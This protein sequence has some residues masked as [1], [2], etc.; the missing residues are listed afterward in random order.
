M[1]EGTPQTIYLKDYQP[2]AFLIDSVDLDIDLRDEQAT[3]RAVLA[4]RRNRACAGGPAPLVLD[5]DDLQF[6]S[7]VLDGTPLPARA[8]EATA[9]RFLLPDAPDVFTLETTVRISPRTNTTLSGL[10]CSKDGYFTQ[11]EA[12]GFR[13]ITYFI[14]RPDV[15]ARY[16]TTIHADRRRYP[17]LLSNG[18]LADSGEEDTGR[19]WARWVDP[20]PKPSYLFAMVAANLEVL[21]DTYRTVSGRTVQLAIYVEPGKLD[22]CGW[23]MQALKKAMKWDEEVFGL[24]VDLDQY[25]IVAVGDFNMGA[26]ENKGLNIFNTKY[27]LAR[28]DVA[29][30][31]DYHKIDRV[32]GHEYFHNWTGNRVTCRDWFQLSLKEGLTVFRDQEFGADLYS[33]GVAR[34]QQVRGL[35]TVQFPEDAGTMAHPVRPASYMEINNFYTPTVYEKGAEVVRMIHTLIGPAR[36]RDGMDIYFRRH[37]GQAVTCE[38]FVRAMQDASGVDL[39]QFM[40][41]YDQAGTPTLHVTD[42]YD[43]HSGRYT[44]RV[45]Q[46]CPSTPGQAEKLPFHIPFTVALLGGDG[47]MLPLQVAGEPHAADRERV[48]SV[49]QAEQL[50]VFE[51]VAERPVPSLLRR[52]SAPVRLEYE[53]T[54]EQLTLLMSHDSDPFSR[55]EAGQRLATGMLLRGAETV[56]SGGEA[57]VPHRIIDAFRRM[58]AGAEADPAFA[59]E[60]ISLPAESVLAEQMQMVDPD[61]L[62]AACRQ[63]RAALAHSLRA[64]WLATYESCRL[65]GAYSPDAASA[66]RR[67]L[68]NT[69]LG[70]LAELQDPSIYALCLRQFEEADNMTDT[71]AALSILANHD[72][73]ERV[74]ALGAFY[75]RWKAEALIV[76]K[77]LSVQATS[78]LPDTLDR[79]RRLLSHPAFELRNPNKV[80]SLIRGFTGANHVRF[81]ARDGR[82]YAFAADQI[83]ALDRI[84][85]QV[86]ARI[87]RCFDR[88]KRFDGAR[89]GS[90]R[91]Q[92]ERI[93]A[94]PGLSR[95]VGEVV[96]RALA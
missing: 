2:P 94:V 27:V 29:T 44:L 33:R 31:L 70:Y 96:A 5:G 87:A 13:R 55:W 62:H 35:R 77:W 69:C 52:F 89:Q 34:V 23:A 8:F 19:H 38:E 24:E 86:A 21:A 30:D 20:H 14:D 66:G 17:L 57:A 1:R 79:V 92:L 48:L 51:N 61:A 58:L 73:A 16:A 85:P 59:A 43:R 80:Y 11:C 4:V 83:I 9:Q 50:I 39:G 15:M 41:W 71:M 40:R 72:C 84:N 36:F 10:Y 12:E 91:A 3:V 78:R 74:H 42:E 88:W 26:M 6:V 49:T 37:D 54:D 65:T 47:A 67:A 25:M 53:Y 46:S 68:R 7:A 28:P 18:N 75:E 82:G 45:R 81:H 56:R 93:R 22:Q 76:D 64:Q 63:V 60:A 90:A 32:V 95:D